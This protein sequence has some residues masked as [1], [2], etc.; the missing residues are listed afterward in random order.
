MAPFSFIT[1]IALALA[2]LN[3][4]NGFMPMRNP[5]TA[6]RRPL[7]SAMSDEPLLRIGHGFDI[8][9]LIEG[10]K[11]V[12]GRLKPLPSLQFITEVDLD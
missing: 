9:R 11:L 8:H 1:F 2:A 7:Q 10:T 4:V 3:A 5:F 6:I 12:I